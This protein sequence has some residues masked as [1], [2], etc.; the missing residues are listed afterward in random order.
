MG[1]LQAKPHWRYEEFFKSTYVIDLQINIPLIK[2]FSF[3]EQ[4]FL[5]LA[6]QNN[7][8]F[9]SASHVRNVWSK[10]NKATV[11]KQ[12]QRQVALLFCKR[13]PPNTAGGFKKLM[14]AQKLCIHILP[15]SKSQ[16]DLLYKRPVC[17]AHP[18]SELS[19]GYAN[20]KII[21]DNGFRLLWQ[22][23]YK[24]CRSCPN[25]RSNCSACP[26]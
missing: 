15:D 22:T 24:I 23:R 4:F 9:C 14:M 25:W 19:K 12:K 1:T 8:L 10:S 18:K 21:Q 3:I 5:D 20:R 13:K 2:E 17:V 7:F 16:W 26:V 6:F 11:I